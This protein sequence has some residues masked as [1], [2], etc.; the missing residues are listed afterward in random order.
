MA[1]QKRLEAGP[2]GPGGRDAVARQGGEL[3]ARVARLEE[4]NRRLA[5]Q[6]RRSRVVGAVALVLIAAVAAVGAATPRTTDYGESDFSFKTVEA[7][8]FFL[9]DTRDELRAAVALVGDDPVMRFYD[10]RGK[11]R[12][13][14]GLIKDQPG[15]SLADGKGV[16][17]TGL[18]VDGNRPGL[19]FWDEKAR[20]RAEFGIGKDG[21]PML[22]IYDED[23][24]AIWKA[25]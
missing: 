8:G 2:E 15:V 18:V 25:P 23:K 13:S 21:A 20:M 4:Q 19:S 12:L 22:E 14:I 17:R 6:Y 11:N 10:T 9:V 3:V 16:A 24:K 5:A 1:R 7:G